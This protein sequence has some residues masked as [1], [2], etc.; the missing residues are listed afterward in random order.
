MTPK[1][2]GSRPFG[3]LLSLIILGLSAHLLRHSYFVARAQFATPPTAYTVILTDSTYYP[4]GKLGRTG[5]YI[6]AVRSDGSRMY[7]MSSPPFESRTIEFANGNKVRVGSMLEIK[8]SGRNMAGTY[9]ARWHRDPKSQCLRSLAGTSLVSGSETIAAVEEVSGYRAVRIT[10]GGTSWYALEQGCALIRNRMTFSDGGYSE[11]TLVALIPGEP[12]QELFH[13][14]EN[15][16]DVSPSEFAGNL[17]RKL[18]LAPLS[19]DELK[20][21]EKHDQDYH[22]RRPQ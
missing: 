5:Q 10:G 1:S 8:S 20:R 14:P 11:K 2:F 9:P 21:Y 7:M 13:I 3:V 4:N 12:A 16:R 18:G 22:A 6:Y 15:F 19:A 17:R